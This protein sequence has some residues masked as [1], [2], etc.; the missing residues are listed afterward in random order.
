MPRKKLY[1][2]DLTPDEQDFLL[3][4]CKTGS[5]PARK[6]LRAN[7]LLKADINGSKWTDKQIQEA[8]DISDTTVEKCRRQFVLEGLEASVNRKKYRASRFL[9]KIDG[10][11]EAK[12]IALVMSDPPEGRDRWTLRLLSQRLVELDI[13][14]SISHETVRQTL[15]KMNLSLGTRNLG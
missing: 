6:V 15:K 4:I 12:L 3:K 13:V 10:S 5:N 8:F 9:K 11:Q 7:I 2:V 14:E 1:V